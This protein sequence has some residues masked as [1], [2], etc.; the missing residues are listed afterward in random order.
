ME[1]NATEFVMVKRVEGD[2][3]FVSELSYIVHETEIVNL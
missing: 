3:L 2:T 1:K